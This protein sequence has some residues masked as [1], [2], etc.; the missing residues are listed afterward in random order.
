MDLVIHSSSYFLT[1]STFISPPL[2]AMK[3]LPTLS[4]A[5]CLSSLAIL[6]P[7]A[8][9]AQGFQP[10]F[11]T[12]Q[13][14]A[15]FGSLRLN[16]PGSQTLQLVL[17]GRNVGAA[18]GNYFW[19]QLSGGM[20]QL[21]VLQPFGGGGSPQWRPFYQGP[22]NLV[23]G[24]QVE[25]NLT[26][27]GRVELVRRTTLGFA[28]PQGPFPGF[29]G[30]CGTP[31]FPPYQ[32]FPQYQ[33]YPSYPNPYGYYPQNGPYGPGGGQWN[34]PYSGYPGGFPSQ[35]IQQMPFPMSPS[36]FNGFLASINALS[37][38]STKQNAL[39]TAFQQNYFTSAQVAQI[40]DGLT[41]E[42]TK[43]AVAKQAFPRTVD[44]QNFHTIYR[45]F[46][47]DSSVSDLSQFI[48]AR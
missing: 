36:D 7:L 39:R 27:D 46:D 30:L 28:Q 31:S 29:P 19:P 22:I 37:F 20:H 5:A 44:P 42:S 23:G 1:L 4:L 26:W 21:Q 8:N 45:N 3:A 24:E 32:G 25:L 2:L 12:Q 34:G 6:L 15:A 48:A 18:S 43:L 35:P 33:G 13:A 9:N 16:L 38:E 14:S 17:D 40:V 47:F 11:V 10:Q 41:F